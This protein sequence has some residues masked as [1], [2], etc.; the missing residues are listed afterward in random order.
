MKVVFA[1]PSLHGLDR[2]RWPEV[3]IRPPA[4]VGD[5]IAA[6][7]AGAAAIGLIDGVFEQQRSVWH[8]EILGALRM[9]AAVLGA[10]SLGA[11]RA[12][13]CEAFGMV[14]IGEIFREY[15]DGRR[16]LDADLAVTFGPAA[17][18]YVPLSVAQVDLEHSLRHILALGLVTAPEAAAIRQ[19]SGAM[20]F[21]TRTLDRLAAA[22]PA[23]A[24]GDLGEMLRRHWVDRKQRDA[25]L[26]LDAMSDGASLAT[27]A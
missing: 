22:C 11:L 26:L 15:R 18:D 3:E 12:V 8:K 20:F 16:H 6:A 27:V 5:V 23:P 1:G 19:I 10:A 9:G 17:L 21:K 4:G 13:E 7:K 24:K 2:S 25:R 14:G